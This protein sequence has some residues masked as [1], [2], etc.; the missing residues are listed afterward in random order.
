MRIRKV[1]LVPVS[2]L[3]NIEMKVAALTKQSASDLA[4]ER[5]RGIIQNRTR[6]LKYADVNEVYAGVPE[7]IER[8]RADTH[9]KRVAKRAAKRKAGWSHWTPDKNGDLLNANE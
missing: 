1:F 8:K 7:L 5:A 3:V 4:T 9:A 6:S 2:I